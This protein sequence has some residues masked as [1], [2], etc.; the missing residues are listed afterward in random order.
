MLVSFTA[1]V[2]RR[3]IRVRQVRRPISANSSRGTRHSTYFPHR[4]SQIFGKSFR[5][6]VWAFRGQVQVFREPPTRS[7]VVWNLAE[8]PKFRPPVRSGL[9]SNWPEC[10]SVLLPRRIEAADAPLATSDAR[11]HS[12]LIRRFYVHN[13]RCLENFELPIS[14]QSSVLLIGNNGS[15]KTTVGSSPW[16]Y[17]RRS[18]AART[19]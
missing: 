19:G 15:G 5:C 1:D 9:L 4:G 18:R 2:L 6:S 10:R 13:F 17:Y 3:W 8:L 16:R 7:R 14:G 12:Y 11:Y